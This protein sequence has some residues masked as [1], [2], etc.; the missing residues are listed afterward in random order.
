MP[1]AKG[2]GTLSR[3]WCGGSIEEHG[4]TNQMRRMKKGDSGRRNSIMRG[5][6]VGKGVVQSD[7]TR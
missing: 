1:S 3:K 4:G 5:K 7:F 6:E 2:M